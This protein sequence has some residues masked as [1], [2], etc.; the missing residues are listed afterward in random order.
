MS[1]HGVVTTLSSKMSDQRSSSPQVKSPFIIKAETPGQDSTAQFKPGF[2]GN[3]VSANDEK[4][5]VSR[6]G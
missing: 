6:N 1:P 4:T 2:F 3:L 5:I